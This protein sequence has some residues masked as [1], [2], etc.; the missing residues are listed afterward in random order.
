MNETIV[1]KKGLEIEL[2]IESLAYGGMG[3]SRK[4]NFIYFCKYTIP[5]QKVLA[6]YKKG[7]ATLKRR[8]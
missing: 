5:G 2:D 7:R 8:S 6:R 1:I 4:E 3:L